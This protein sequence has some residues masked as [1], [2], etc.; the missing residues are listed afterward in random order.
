MTT[1]EEWEVMVRRGTSGE[2]VHD[3]LVDLRRAV[4][5]SAWLESLLVSQVSKHCDLHGEVAGEWLRPRL[6]VSHPE[7]EVALVVIDVVMCLGRQ[8][9][10]LKEH[11]RVL[12]GANNWCG[13]G[14]ETDD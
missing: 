2:M 6:H 12:E 9:D 3:M 13:D 1:I 8:V 14:V 10:E 4:L 11:V 5:Y 7:H